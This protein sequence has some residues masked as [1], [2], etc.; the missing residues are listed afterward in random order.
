MDINRPQPS[1]RVKSKLTDETDYT[2]FTVTPTT[3]I[4]Q[5]T[6]VPDT[7][8]LHKLENNLSDPDQFDVWL[9][10]CTTILRQKGPKRDATSPVQ[11]KLIQTTPRSW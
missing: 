1:S 8:Q 11:R 10:A 9:D 4:T 5:I 2:D 3:E 6:D 7:Y